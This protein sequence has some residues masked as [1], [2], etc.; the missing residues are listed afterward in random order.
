MVY[1]RAQF[2]CDK[3]FINREWHYFWTNLIRNHDHGMFSN[4]SYFLYFQSGHLRWV[5]GLIN[6]VWWTSWCYIYH[7]SYMQM[8]EFMKR[9]NQT[10]IWEFI[11]L[12]LSDDPAKQPLLF[13]LLLCIYLITMVGNLLIILTI[14]SNACFHSP[15]YYFL[16]NLSLIDLCLSSTTVP[17]MLVDI[18]TGNPTISF[19]NCMMQMSLFTCFS[20]METLLLPIMSYD[21]FVAICLPL[22]YLSIMTPKLCACLVA[23]S[24][25]FAILS[26]QIHTILLVQLPFCKDNKIPQFF[27]DIGPLLKLSCSDTRIN[28]IFI[29]I[30]GGLVVVVSFICI[31]VSYILIG[32]AIVRMPST[33][34]KFK[35]FSTCSSHICV[36][37]LFFGTII[38]VYLCPSNPHIVERDKA[39]ALMYTVITPL[40]NPFIYSLRNSHLTGVLR[41]TIRKK[42]FL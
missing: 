23:S 17:K 11:L 16:S 5:D 20:G 3:M 4:K 22:S 28:E 37:L 19:N 9:L 14:I 33:T 1:R 35:A 32:F 15:M 31:L 41:K 12:G 40:L 39:A 2:E 10:S 24:W 34:G 42:L 6:S 18:Q 7:K 13:S 38:G 29:F 36:V 8:I 25:F 30:E 27:C 21:R 26:A